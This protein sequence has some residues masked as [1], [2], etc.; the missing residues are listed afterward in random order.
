VGV[1]DL[2]S[3][4]GPVDEQHHYECIECGENLSPGD[5]RCPTCG[6]PVSRYDVT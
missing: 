2:F 5:G 3:A 1:R 4:T 6:G